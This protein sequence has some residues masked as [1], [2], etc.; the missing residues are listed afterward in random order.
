MIT[1]PAERAGL[2]FEEG[3]AQRILNDTGTEPGAL[4]LMAFALFELW[5]ESRGAIG[6]MTKAAYESF[7]GVH[8]AIGKRAEDTFKGLEGQKTR[9]EAAFT[10]VFGKLVEVDERGVATRRRARINQVTDGATAETLVRTMIDARLLVTSRDEGNEAMVEVAHEAIFTNWRRLSDWIESHSGELRTC[11]S[12]IRA[13]KDW[14]QAGAPSFRHLP[15][16]ATLKLYRKIRSACALGEHAEVVSGYF[17]AARQRQ[18]LWSGSLTLVALVIGILGGDTWLRNREM[19]WNMLRIW[20]L[21]Q[22]GLYDGPPMV[23]IPGTD[24]PF[25]MG[26]PNCT[27]NSESSECPKHPVNIQP[28]WMGKYEVTFDEYSAFLLDKDFSEPELP[29]DQ[30]WG[31]RKRPVIRIRLGEAKAYAAWLAGVTGRPF[32]LPS[33][34]EWEYAARAGSD[35]IYWWGNERDYNMANCPFFHRDRENKTMPV[36]SFPANPFGLHDMLGNVWEW[37]ADSW[38]QTYDGA[39]SDGQAWIEGG[40]SRM[41]RGGSYN[42]EWRDCRSTSR[43]PDNRW[44]EDEYTDVGIRIAR[45]V[46][47]SP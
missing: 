3:L 47:N 43:N 35:T 10:H 25:L 19:S 44:P 34:A 1:R 2:Q 38:H 20:A 16:R 41:M 39:P 29:H 12:L 21:V 17:R 32:R 14:Q 33:E 40:V 15:D 22:V 30:D 42:S 26:H 28:F 13:A 18:W 9:L 37:V 4:A 36:G 27:P 11:R 7:N 24:T 31:R 23:K 8:G 46:S 5:N 45:S 6:S